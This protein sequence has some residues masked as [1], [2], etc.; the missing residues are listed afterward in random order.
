M[1]E[2]S[3]VRSLLRQVEA[4]RVEQQGA[5]VEQVRIEIGPLAGVEP[6]LVL[7]AF[8]ELAPAAGMENTDLVIDEVTLTARCA[9]CGLVEVTLPRIACP[10]CGSVTVRIVSGDQVRLQSVTIR[11]AT[12]METTP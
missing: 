6:L 5:E 11:Q 10:V 4:I 8:S 1:H 3:L 9:D 12:G 7:S 2:S